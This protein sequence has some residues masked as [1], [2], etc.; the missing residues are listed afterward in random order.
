[1]Q[2]KLEGALGKD[3]FQSLVVITGVLCYPLMLYGISTRPPH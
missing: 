3:V 1:M 2:S